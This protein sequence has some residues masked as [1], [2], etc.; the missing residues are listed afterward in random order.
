M[1]RVRSQIPASS[2][3]ATRAPFLA[4]GAVRAAARFQAALVELVAQFGPTRDCGRLAGSLDALLGARAEVAVVAV[5]VSLAAAVPGVEVCIRGG[6]PSDVSAACTSEATEQ[7]QQQ[8]ESNARSHL[9]MISRCVATI[10]VAVSTPCGCDGRAR[11]GRV[12]APAR[13]AVRADVDSSGP[14]Y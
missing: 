13:S 12:A 14:A 9:H 4:L 1:I 7:E 10:Q 11:C 3:A 2:E 8:G 5:F 6:I